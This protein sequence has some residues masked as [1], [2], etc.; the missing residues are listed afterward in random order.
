M[1]YH[2]RCLY[3]LSLSARLSCNSSGHRLPR[4]HC[5]TLRPWWPYPRHPGQASGNPSQ[6][7]YSGHPPQL[8]TNKNTITIGIDIENE[9][10]TKD[11]K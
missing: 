1:S 4:H 8:E 5:L 6:L 9:Q 2:I 3:R 11:T 10:T 7:T